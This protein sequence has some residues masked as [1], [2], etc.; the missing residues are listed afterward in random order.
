MYWNDNFRID[1]ISHFLKA[2]TKDAFNLTKATLVN[3]SNFLAGKLE[4]FTEEILQGLYNVNMSILMNLQ[5]ILTARTINCI[6][7]A[8]ISIYFNMYTRA[9]VKMP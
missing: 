8:M 4:P 6:T 2:I 3:W 5:L 1:Y 7:T 9:K